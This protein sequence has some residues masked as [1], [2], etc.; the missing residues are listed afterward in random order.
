VRA[1]VLA[2]VALAA[3]A[4]LSGC[5]EPASERAPDPASAPGQT[6]AV[7]EAKARDDAAAAREARRLAELWT[8][9]DVPVEGGR[10]LSASINSANDVDSGGVTPGRVQ[11][12]FRDHPSW[13]RSSYL[14]LQAGDFACYGG[15]MVSVAV[16]DGAPSRMAARRPVTDEAIAMF[17]DDA[18]ALWRATAGTARLGI[19]FPVKAGGSLTAVFDVAGLDRSRMPGWD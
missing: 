14:L 9:H 2:I 11:L 8:Y 7:D 13:G 12:V 15:C 3:I 1:L 5:G 6:A 4:G 19:E 18:Q 10:Q 16:N 17:I